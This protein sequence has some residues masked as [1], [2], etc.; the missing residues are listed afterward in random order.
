MKKSINCCIAGILAV[1]C[2]CSAVS[3]EGQAGY[4]EYISMLKSCENPAELMNVETL[5]WQSNSDYKIVYADNN[6]V[7]FRCETYSYSGGAHG[8][9]DTKVGTIKNGKLLKLADLPDLSKIQTLWQQA[10]QAHCQFA[11]IKKYSDFIGSE[12]QLTENFYLDDKGI[13]F[14]YQPY[15]IAPFA[16]GTI[17]IFIPLPLGVGCI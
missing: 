7:S 10:L 16:A 6:I 8:M 3:A 2:G 11:E 5:H 4:Q 14:I 1:L 12:P 17:E 13:H 15:E 9:P